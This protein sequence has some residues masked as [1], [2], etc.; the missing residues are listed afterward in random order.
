MKEK[1]FLLTIW[2]RC[3]MFQNHVQ[4]PSC[5][6][7][8]TGLGH[9]GVRLGSEADNWCFQYMD[10]KCWVYQYFWASYLLFT[11]IWHLIKLKE[12]RYPIFIIMYHPSLSEVELIKPSTGL[13]PFRN[14]RLVVL[15]LEVALKN[16]PSGYCLFAV[17]KCNT[18]LAIHHV[19]VLPWE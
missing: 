4:K 10:L 11:T 1:R 15:L 2:G 18:C 19:A 5:L 9:W 7:S 16:T 17:S 8:W 14:C 13:D 12:H 3:S 6:F